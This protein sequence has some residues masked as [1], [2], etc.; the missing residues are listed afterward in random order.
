MVDG[1]RWYLTR[2][3]RGFAHVYA[4]IGTAENPVDVC[5]AVILGPVPGA[6]ERA[7][8]VTKAPEMRDALRAFLDA[9]PAGATWPVWLSDAVVGARAALGKVDGA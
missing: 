8:L 1:E 2:S 9:L 7:A 6:A 4:S 3:S 5:V